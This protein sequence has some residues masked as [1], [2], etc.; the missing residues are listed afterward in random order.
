MTKSEKERQGG[1]RKRREREMVGGGEGKG[2]ERDEVP[3]CRSESCQRSQ[4]RCWNRSRGCI[5]RSHCLQS[6]CDM[7]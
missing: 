4:H 6:S 2:E 3:D 7:Y 5:R 1:G